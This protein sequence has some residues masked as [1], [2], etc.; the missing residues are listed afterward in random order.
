MKNNK[1]LWSE[2][3]AGEK[4]LYILSCPFRAIYQA[5]AYIVKFFGVILNVCL[6]TLVVAAIAGSILFAHFKPMYED[7]CEQAYDKLSNLSE[8]D[9]HMLSNTVVYD[10]DGKKIGEIDSGSYVYVKIDKISKYVQQGYMS[11]EDKKFMEHGGV[12]LQS[13]I[14]AA[15]SLWSHDGEITQGGS[16][17]TQQV[18]KNNLLTQKQ[19]YS[20]K[21]TEVMLAPAL[22]SKFTKA[23]IMEFYCNS[24]FYGN[25]CYGIETASKFYFGCSAKDLTLAQA[26]MLCG[27]S[28]SPNKYNPIASMELAKKKQ[29]Q[30]LEEMLADG[31]ITKKEYKAALK[32]KI[33]VVGLDE[34]TSSENYMV[35][36]AIDCAT[37]Q[38]MTDEGF[39]FKYSFAD[40]KEQK[41][42]K[43][44]YV[45]EYSA[46]STEIRAGGFKIYTSF[47]QKI[48]KKLQNSVIKTLASF[49]EK[50]KKTKKYALQ[51]AAMCID[52]ETQY[53]VAVVG[54]R[55]KNDPYNRAFLST[56]QPGSS[57]KP[58]LDY[59][60]AIDNGVINGSTVM[61]DQKVY[62]DDY[63]K[64]SYSPSNS[65]GGYRGSMTIREALTRSINTIAFQTFKK[66]GSE[67]ALSY[68]DKMKF[69]SLS[70]ADN[71][72][73]AISLGGFTN[74]VT[75]N[76]MCR[77]YAT[78]ANNGQMSSRTCLV[79][80]DH[81]TKGNIYTAPE[82]DDSQTQVFSSDTA[83]I[84]QDLLQGPITEGFGTGHR[85][86]NSN[87][88][89]AG[90]TGTTNSNK[91]AWFC[92]FS[93][94]YTTSVWIGYDTPR[95]MPGM[96]GGTYPLKIW[97]GFMDSVHKNKKKKNFDI[98]A[99]IELRRMAGGEYTDSSK[100]ISYS[101]DKPYYSQRPA[102]YDYYSQQNAD[103][104]KQWEKD[105]KLESA[106]KAAEKAVAE[107]EKYTIKSAQD[108]IN[109]E[110]KYND[111]LAVIAQIPDE[112][113]Q[114]SYKERA[115]SKY[116]SLQEEALGK[117]QDAIK[118]YNETQR[119]KTEKQKKLDAEDA[120]NK[121]ADEVKKNRIK[122][123]QWYTDTLNK[124]NYYTSATKLLIEDGKKAL[125]KVE[126]YSEYD[127]MKTKFEEAVARAE[128]LPVK[129][130]TPVVPTDGSDNS[131]IDSGKYSEAT[132]TPEP[133]VTPEPTAEPQ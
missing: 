85:A 72:A 3:T 45:K 43:K 51:S 110:T 10:K 87:Q 37:L 108:A 19:T 81:E 94:Y 89:Y 130:E 75:I 125:K 60:P 118:E 62:W 98:P 30:V 113:E 126:G 123:L 114:S 12:N 44:K 63:D 106:K 16:T 17:I 102:G 8:K 68:L 117:W 88:I 95:R 54:G 67:T 48:Q 6:I 100:N 5:V 4:A 107:F 84:M 39:E 7:A 78:I 119:D 74:G 116:K 34:T 29:A 24:N 42:Y 79:K 58:L 31:Y 128:A 86:Y 32:E 52:N 101:A 124:R 36:Y 56:R 41:A 55:S 28:N 46:R 64:K 33:D 133:T 129:A 57:I 104:K 22:E 61:T 35:S 70:Y 103:R 69:S 83:F 23:D 109:F 14:R 120:V 11:S 1:K 112:Y 15:L 97:S 2:R 121:A 111:V 73:P 131:K 20:R 91:D 132:A 38:M 50:D 82:L 53:V 47:D 9:F 93:A 115:A 127:S 27:V 92:G 80:V 76:N 13:I 71:T 25:R 49:T 99:T 21:L 105:Y 59:G 96:Y 122:K 66:M 90:K 40:A 18:I 26:A 65:G 77:G